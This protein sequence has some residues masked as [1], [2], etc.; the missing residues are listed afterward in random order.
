MGNEHSGGFREA[1]RAAA[2][3][4][5]KDPSRDMREVDLCAKAERNFKQTLM[6][7]KDAYGDDDG[8]EMF[9]RVVLS[10]QSY[11]SDNRR[12]IQTLVC[13]GARASSPL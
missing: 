5:A 3:V 11:Q 13:V 12:L 9:R 6:S 2:D 8:A 10:P 1:S 4:S 7:M